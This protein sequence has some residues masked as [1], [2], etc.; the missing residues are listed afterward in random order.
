MDLPPDAACMDNKQEKKRSID[1]VMKKHEHRLTLLHQ[2]EPRRNDY[3]TTSF[4]TF[5]EI[6]S[7]GFY[8]AVRQAN[9]L[10]RMSCEELVG[11]PPLNLPNSDCFAL[12]F[13]I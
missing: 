13:L 1:S 9:I 5:A 8:T 10:W 6:H 3:C 11:L 2:R 7:H 4:F 12:V